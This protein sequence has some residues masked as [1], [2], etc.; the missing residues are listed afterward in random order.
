[1]KLEEAIRTAIQYETG[2]RSI[3]LSAAEKSRDA[4]GKKVFRLLAFEEREHLELLEK[5]LQ[6][7]IDSGTLSE[8]QLRSAVPARGSIAASVKEARSKL[9][10]PD[11]AQELELLNRAL[12]LEMETSDFYRKMVNELDAE[13]QA[14]FDPLVECEEGHLGL[15]QA[16]IDSLTGLGFWFDMREFDLETG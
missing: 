14:L 8:F 9:S 5:L 12:Q 15:V 10:E 1:M 13:G 11:K 6:E 7:W 4:T 3:Y 2:I 16:Q